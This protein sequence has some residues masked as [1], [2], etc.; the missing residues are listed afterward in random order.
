M[1]R[2]YGEIESDRGEV[3]K[4]GNK[5]IKATLAYGS[6]SN[7][8]GHVTVQM[9]RDGNVTIKTYGNITINPMKDW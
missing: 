3:H 4:I 9:D 2:L 5:T 8:I 6:E 7:W 1:A